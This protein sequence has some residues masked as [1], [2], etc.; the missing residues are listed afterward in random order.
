VAEAAGDAVTVTFT[1]HILGRKMSVDADMLVL[2]A[3][4]RPE[5]TE[6][7][8][9]IMKL[10]RNPENYFIE[11]HVKLRPVEMGTEGVYLCGTAHAP[12][13]LTESIAQAM[14]A[15]SRATTMLSQPHLT[16]SAVTAH[17]NPEMCASCLI[18]VRTCPYKVPKINEE[19]VSFIDDALCQGCGACAAECPAKAIELNWYEDEQILSKVDSLLEGAI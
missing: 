18:C 13:L 19:G 2:S 10:N 12:K 1:D 16:L 7:L 11:A 9:T 3:G 8:S 5:D 15:A 4:M 14:A 17:V 6:E